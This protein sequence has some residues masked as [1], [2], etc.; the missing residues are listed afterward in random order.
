MESGELQNY[1][2]IARDIRILTLKAI[3]DLGLGHVGGAMSIVEIL[4]LLYF[5]YMKINPEKPD[6]PERDTLVLSKGHAGPALYSTLALRGYFPREWL[7]T[8]NRGGTRLPSHCDMNRTPGIDMTTGSLGQGISSAIGMAL[9]RRLDNNPARTYLI[10]GDGE[11]NEGQVW[12]GAMA[13]AHHKLD[14]I[15]A[16]IDYNG[17]QIDGPVSEVMD[18]GDI[19]AKWS[20]FGWHVQE[21]DGHDFEQINAAVEAAHAQAGQPSVVILKTVKGKGVPEFEGKVESHNMNFSPEQ[22]S[23]VIKDLEKVR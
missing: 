10:L 13:A 23:A 22:C 9:A 12:E 4:T 1:T 15:T 5:R 6:W 7:Y 16:F 21:V 18:I 2:R 19:N 11:N 20:S 17:L 8:L 14:S 3:A